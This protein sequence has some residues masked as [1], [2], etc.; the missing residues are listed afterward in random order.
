MKLPTESE[1]NLFVLSATSDC[2]SSNNFEVS[3]QISADF[4]NSFF[5]KEYFKE[6]FD[7]VGTVSLQ[8]NGVRNAFD[9]DRVIHNLA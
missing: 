6:Y 1:C 2:V 9:S 4:E 7:S 8:N 5:V 3:A